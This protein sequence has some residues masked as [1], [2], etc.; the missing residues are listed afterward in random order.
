M[1]KHPP[2]TKEYALSVAKQ[3][4]SELRKKNIPFKEVR[5]FGSTAKN[6]IHTWSD[7]DIAI[8]CEPFLETKTDEQHMCSHAARNIDVRSEV[9]CLHPEDLENKYFTLAKEVQRYGIVADAD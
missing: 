9:V 8:I 3:L 1:M 4:Q 7:I 2:L 6:E 5:L